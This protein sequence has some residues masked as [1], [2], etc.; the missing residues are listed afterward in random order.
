MA[1]CINFTGDYSWRQ[2]K[3]VERGGFPPIRTSSEL[4]VLYF[5]VRQTTPCSSPENRQHNA[6]YVDCSA[7]PGNGIV[8][9]IKG[10]PEIWE[11]GT[12]V[13]RAGIESGA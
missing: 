1:L 13:G 3:R 2:N 10:D 12:P 9:K 5:P 7:F 4:S 8:R 6:D 11:R